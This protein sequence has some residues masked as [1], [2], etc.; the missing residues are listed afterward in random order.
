MCENDPR[1]G[2]KVVAVEPS[3]A[4]AQGICLNGFADMRW[5]IRL[6]ICL[7][8]PAQHNFT[9]I[10]NTSPKGAPSFANHQNI[11]SDH[12]TQ[13]CWRI[14]PRSALAPQ[15]FLIN[16]QLALCACVFVCW[17][18]SKVSR[19]VNTH[20]SSAPPHFSSGKREVLGGK[21]L[22]PQL[23]CV[24]R[25]K[26]PGPGVGVDFG[27]IAPTHNRHDAPGGRLLAISA[28]TAF[29]GIIVCSGS[30]GA[31]SNADNGASDS[32]RDYSTALADKVPSLDAARGACTLFA[33]QVLLSRTC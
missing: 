19:S 33:T 31:A 32:S 30:A 13:S 7:A 27:R 3:R 8:R 2:A 26:P 14:L 9:R 28:L 20:A 5:H 21:T 4:S 15:I 17:R 6:L 18:G 12:D 16:I 25:Q 24:Y 22:P 1:N 23:C 10:I 29:C 11:L